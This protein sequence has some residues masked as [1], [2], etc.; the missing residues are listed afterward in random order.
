MITKEQVRIVWRVIGPIAIAIVALGTTACILQERMQDLREIAQDLRDGQR[1][2]EDKID[3]L[4]QREDPR[5]AALVRFINE[6]SAARP[7]FDPDCW[8]YTPD[9]GVPEPVAMEAG[10]ENGERGTENGEPKADAAAADAESCDGGA[11]SV[12]PPSVL[13]S[14]FSVLGSPFATRR[15]PFDPPLQIRR[16]RVGGTLVTIEGGRQDDDSRRIRGDPVPGATD[17]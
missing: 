11:C 14:P 13:G 15:L 4:L 5:V 10:T 12:D 8:D 2:I 3:K 9:G 17:D 6:Q 16:V 1:R 7:I